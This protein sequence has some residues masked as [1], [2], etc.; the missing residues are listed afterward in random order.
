MMPNSSDANKVLHIQ[1]RT[2]TFFIPPGQKKEQSS[3]TTVELYSQQKKTAVL[4]PFTSTWQDEDYLVTVVKPRK[5]VLITRS[6][7]TNREVQLNAMSAFRDSL[8]QQGTVVMCEKGNNSAHETYVK[9]KLTKAASIRTHT[10]TMEFWLDD[11]HVLIKKLRV[12]YSVGQMQ[13]HNIVTI[14]KQEL[15]AT[16]DVLMSSARRQ[17]LAVDGHLLPAYAGYRLVDQSVQ[18]P[19]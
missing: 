8:L 10:Q 15:L 3:T 6:V 17:V 13:T 5:T 2:E 14:T 1:M 9:L 4:T 18:R 11:K 19:K 12:N 16:S 7:P